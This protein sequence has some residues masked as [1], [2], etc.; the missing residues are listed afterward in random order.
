MLLGREYIHLMPRNSPAGSRHRRR[1]SRGRGRKGKPMSNFGT[2]DAQQFWI[3]MRKGQ[4]NQYCRH[5]NNNLAFM[6]A[7]RLSGK[8]GDTFFVL[9]VVGICRPSAPPIQVIKHDQ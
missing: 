5:E 3:V 6:E 2:N 4:M 1:C 8:H 9:K 7:E